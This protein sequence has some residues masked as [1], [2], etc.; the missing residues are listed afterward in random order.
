MEEIWNRCNMLRIYTK[1]CVLD[2][3]DDVLDVTHP[4]WLHHHTSQ[5]V[6]S[7]IMKNQ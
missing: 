1:V 7:L 3:M 5:K 2:W 6:K 4:L